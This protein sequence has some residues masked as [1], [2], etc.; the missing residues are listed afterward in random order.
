MPSNISTVEIDGRIVA[1]TAQ[2]NAAMDN[3]VLLQGALA[4]ERSKVQALEKTA[5][6]LKAQLEKK[7]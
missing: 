5:A 3:I 2:R 4:V 1:L 6:E 7:E